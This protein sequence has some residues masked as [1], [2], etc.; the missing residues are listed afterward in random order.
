ML[1]ELWW[2][3]VPALG[4]AAYHNDV[5]NVDRMLRVAAEGGGVDVNEPGS[6]PGPQHHKLSPLGFAVLGD[7]PEAA[8]SLLRSGADP[9]GLDADNFPIA[10]LALQKGRRERLMHMIHGG[11]DPDLSYNGESLAAYCAYAHNVEAIIALVKAGTSLDRRTLGQSPLAAHVIEVLAEPDA[12]RV[13][14]AMHDDRPADFDVNARSGVQTRPTLLMHAVERGFPSVVQD[15]LD[16][17]AD[18]CRTDGFDRPVEYYVTTLGP[19]AQQEMR[20]VLPPCK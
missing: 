13:L 5:R 15:L 10:L 6:L 20:S 17:G 18:P 16:W 7:A 2:M 1:N 8:A 4:R 12:R 3:G 9:N 11:V 14:R 19:Q